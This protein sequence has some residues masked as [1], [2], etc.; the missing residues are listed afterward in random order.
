MR[1]LII[2]FIAIFGIGLMGVLILMS[3][4]G[5]FDFNTVSLY[6]KKVLENDKIDQID[7]THTSTDVKIIPTK[8]QNMTVELNGKVSKRVKDQ[9]KLDVKE[10]GEKVKIAVIR[11]DNQWFS[12]LDLNNSNV[13]LNLKLPEKIYELIHINLSSGDMDLKEI[14][15]KEVSLITSSGDINV[16]KGEVEKRLS[17]NSS[18]GDLMLQNLKAETLHV[19]LASGDSSIKHIETKSVMLA[20]KSGNVQMNDVKGDIE[21][22]V[23]SA[24]TKIVNN[25]MNSDI[26]IESSSGDV[27]IHFQK[28]PQS[29]NLNYDGVSGEGTVQLDGI[30]YEEKSDHRLKG[31]IGKG[32]RILDVMT[33]SGDFNLR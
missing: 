26:K 7:I 11:D 20:S 4:F 8:D 21:V 9:Y 23:S 15:A 1:K 24:D 13:D 5:G 28:Q 30:L 25:E 16:K 14:Q 3:S 27:D 17:I 2:L 18:S 12:G 29:L 6:E 33:A 19:D 22:V 32:E 10:D 31:K